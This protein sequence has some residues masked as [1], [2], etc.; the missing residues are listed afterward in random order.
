[1]AWAVKNLLISENLRFVVHV[2]PGG[3]RSI[4][5]LILGGLGIGIDYY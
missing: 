5:N 3:R 4:L 1:M 2:V